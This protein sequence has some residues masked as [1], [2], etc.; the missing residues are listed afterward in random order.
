MSAHHTVEGATPR[1]EEGGASRAAKI[2]RVRRLLA[3]LDEVALERDG[4]GNE[5][6]ADWARADAESLMAQLSTL[7]RRKGGARPRRLEGGDAAAVDLDEDLHDIRWVVDFNDRR[8]PIVRD[9]ASLGASRRPPTRPRSP[10]L[11]KPRPRKQPGSR[12]PPPQQQPE[13]RQVVLQAVPAADPAKDERIRQLE[14]T[15][16][17]LTDALSQKMVDEQRRQQALDE[18]R[19]RSREMERSKFLSLLAKMEEMEKA[20]N[21]Q[22]DKM[23]RLEEEH[24]RLQS[25]ELEREHGQ[26]TD[27]RLMLEHHQKESGASREEV[28]ELKRRHADET[29]AL[30]R[31]IERLKEALERSGAENARLAEELDRATAERNELED[32]TIALGARA[33]A[34]EQANTDLQRMLDEMRAEHD[35]LRSK[36]RWY[37][38]KLAGQKDRER[39]LKAKLTRT[40]SGVLMREEPRIN[41]I[42]T[43][44]MKAWYRDRYRTEKERSATLQARLSELRALM[45]TLRENHEAELTA[46][47]KLH[48]A[49][50][51]RGGGEGA[52]L[53]AWQEE[54]ERREAEAA[55][56]REEMELK[57]REN[58]VDI[59]LLRYAQYLEGCF[60]GDYLLLR[61][62]PHVLAAVYR[63]GCDDVLFSDNMTQYGG[64]F[65]GK[66]RRVL[67]ITNKAV[68]VF[69][70]K[71]FRPERIIRVSEIKSL[72]VSRL[73]TDIF[74]IHHEAEGDLLL[75]C[76]KRAEVMYN[77]ML[78]HERETGRRL[79]YRFGERMYE[80]G[81]NM[82]HRDVVIAPN[83]KHSVSKP[84]LFAPSATK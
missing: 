43:A 1:G 35:G 45:D 6:Y 25:A 11:S 83:Q 67:A 7:T 27:I 18:D 81:D 44:M 79:D 15:V 17:Q 69:R 77:L 16:R 72:S 58:N 38:T 26:R 39:M 64:L 59:G 65:N 36:K 74:V 4:R 22:R 20:A 13:P 31:E 48:A 78:T 46:L 42:M 52:D 14:D 75:M 76:A 82:M 73:R 9:P 61:D 28:E 57:K 32:R 62:N 3:R 50:G 63:H 24:A 49:E 2:A 54:L 66:Q 68:Y 71:T 33:T 37:K 10:R 5:V 51:G 12:R 40:T 21:E 84:K 60:Q 53:R 30:R 47:R 23:R 80:R 19:A 55:A 34:L 70:P 8:K 56:F 29:E 41:T